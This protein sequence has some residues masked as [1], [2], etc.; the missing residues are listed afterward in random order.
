M[1]NW[2]SLTDIPIYKSKILLSEASLSG[3]KM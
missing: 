3:N 2:K 1:Q